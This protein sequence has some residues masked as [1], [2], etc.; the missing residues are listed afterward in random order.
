[1]NDLD[2]EPM[3]GEIGDSNELLKLKEKVK[4]L[5][6]QNAIL[7]QKEGDDVDGAV[8]TPVGDEKI[9]EDIQLIEIEDLDESEGNWLLNVSDETADLE[10]EC[11]WLRKDVMSP[12]TLKKKSL[13]NKLDDIAKSKYSQNYIIPFHHHGMF[14]IFARIY[15]F[16]LKKLRAVEL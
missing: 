3:D 9:I 2:M 13:V 14:K 11:S 8:S 15:H 1:M 5:E 10:D 16:M 7:K 4:A 12:N 6:K